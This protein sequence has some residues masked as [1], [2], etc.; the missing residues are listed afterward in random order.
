M[1]IGKLKEKFHQLKTKVLAVHAGLSQQTLPLKVLFWFK[2]EL[3]IFQNNNLLTAQ[4]P[5]EIRDA[6]VDGWTLLS[7][8]SLIT[9]SQQLPN[10]PMSPE[11]K[12]VP[13]MEDKLR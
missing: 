7:N 4:D 11:T 8:T 12:T 2:E 3:K 6:A 9:V 10:I 13:L 5:T 1:S